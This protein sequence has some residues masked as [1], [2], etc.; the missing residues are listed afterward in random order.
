VATGSASLDGGNN[1]TDAASVVYE[2]VTKR[3][4]G[5]ESPAVQDLSLEVPAG[6]ICV[7][8]GPSGCGKTTAM[9]MVNRMVEITEGDIKV[10]GTSVRDR[11]AAALRR[12]IGYVIQQVG[13]FPHRTVAANIGTVPHLLGWHCLISSGSAQTSATAFPRSSREASSSGLASP[14]PW[15]QTRT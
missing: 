6:E 10:G 7:L 15:P 1:G 2:Q 13:L 14:G 3:Y 11:D 9:R 4:P 5:Q 8:V 12:E